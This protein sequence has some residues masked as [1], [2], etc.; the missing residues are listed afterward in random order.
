MASYQ[1]IF[2]FIDGTREDI[3][4]TEDPRSRINDWLERQQGSWIRISE[5][6]INLDTVKRIE[7]VEVDESTDQ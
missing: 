5:S 6:R 2:S 3:T 1:V 4:Y 7:V